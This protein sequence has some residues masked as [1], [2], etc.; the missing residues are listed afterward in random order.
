MLVTPDDLSG[1]QVQF[2][3]SVGVG[4][5]ETLPASE[6]SVS[7]TAGDISLDLVEGPS[8]EILPNVQSGGVT[9]FAQYTF[10]N[11]NEAGPVV[12]TV[13][14]AGESADFDLSGE[15]PIV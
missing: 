3:V 4:P 1:G 12:V 6:L 9:A 7:V 10:A 5:D 14:L 11:P 2:H 15:P 13:S 8:D